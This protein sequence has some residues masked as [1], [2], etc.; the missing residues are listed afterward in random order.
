MGLRIRVLSSR[1]VLRLALRH[2]RAMQ[3]GF[4]STQPEVRGVPHFVLE[5]G[6]R[7]TDVSGA[8][9]EAAF[10]E[11]FDHVSDGSARIR[12]NYRRGKAVTYSRK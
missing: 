12:Q 3:L 4:K 1:S 10:Q 6:A 2:V 5:F 7:R 8:Q 11:A 9:P